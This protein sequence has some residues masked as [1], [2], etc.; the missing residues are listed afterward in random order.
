MKKLVLIATM[1]LGFMAI[2]AGVGSSDAQ[3]Q[4]RDGWRRGEG[5]REMRHMGP[6][7][8]HGWD[9]GRHRG[10][11]KQHRRYDRRY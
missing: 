4:G 10:W 9:R 2:G 1:L 3:A 5:H 8:H 7:R 11:A 6:R